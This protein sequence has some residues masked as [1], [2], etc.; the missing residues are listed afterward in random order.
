MNIT[1]E[2]FQTKV[3]DQEDLVV[4]DFWAPWCGPCKMLA[5]IFE[6]AQN[7]K[8]NVFFGKINVDEESEL[9]VRFGVQSIPTIIFIKK[10]ELLK[11]AIGYM[12]KSELIKLIEVL[13]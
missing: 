3:M 10:G 5:P 8:D 6:E 1:K 9:A 11:E 12:S 4:L 13:E 2:N 7:E